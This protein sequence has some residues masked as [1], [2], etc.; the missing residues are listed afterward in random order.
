MKVVGALCLVVILMNTCDRFT[1]SRQEPA[2]EPTV[3]TAAPPLTQEQ[4]VDQLQRQIATGQD[5]VD[6]S[7]ARLK[8]QFGSIQTAGSMKI[9]IGNL[10]MSALSVNELT[11]TTPD[12]QRQAATLS[13][14]ADA[15]IER[16]GVQMRKEFASGT[17]QVALDNGMNMEVTT[18]GRDARTLRVTHALMSR[19]MVYSLHNNGKIGQSAANFGFNRIIYRDGYNEYW[20]VDL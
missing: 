13:K 11:D 8:D 7:V 2:P 16:I 3:P 5:L 10:T 17:D 9:H 14:Q 6:R 12:E 1:P 15:M 4:R 19:Q 18:R 20:T